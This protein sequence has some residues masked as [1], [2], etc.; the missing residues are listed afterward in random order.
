MPFKKFD[1]PDSLIPY[2]MFVFGILLVTISNKYETKIVKKKLE[3]L[4]KDDK[5][6]GKM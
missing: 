6:N 1:F 5:K 3:E 2:L 4:L